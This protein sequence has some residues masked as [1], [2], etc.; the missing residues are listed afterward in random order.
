[1]IGKKHLEWL[2]LYPSLLVSGISGGALK[3]IQELERDNT[4]T[5]VGIAVLAAF[6][7]ASIGMESMYQRHIWFFVGWALANPI[8]SDCAKD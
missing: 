7:G 1:M 6:V 3:A 4:A 2:A 8:C 5:I